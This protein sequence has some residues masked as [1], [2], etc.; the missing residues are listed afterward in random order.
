MIDSRNGM[1]NPSNLNTRSGLAELIKSYNLVKA[2]PK[3]QA[4]DTRG[5]KQVKSQ[6]DKKGLSALKIVHLK[7]PQILDHTG[8]VASKTTTP[9]QQKLI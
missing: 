9:R 6:R 3:M 8:L 1:Q 2:K 5:I 7:A 4:R